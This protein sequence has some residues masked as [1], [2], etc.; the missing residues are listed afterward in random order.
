MSIALTEDHRALAETATAFLARRDARGSARSLL[1]APDEGLPPWWAELADLGWLGLHVPEELGGSG[2]TLEETAV[3]IEQLGRAVAPGPFVPTVIASA[4]LATC[5]GAPAKDHVPGLTDGTTLGAV[6]L[7]SATTVVVK[8][9]KASGPAGNVLGGGLAHVIL[10][11][12][13]DDVAVIDVAEAGT[14]VTVDV[15][16]NMDPTRR[17]ARVTLD[18]APVTV[19]PGARQVLVDLA[20]VVLSAEAVGLAREC[21]EMAAAY[22]KERLQFGRPIAMFQAV[23]HHCA[24]MAVATELATSA[25]WDAAKASST[26]GDQLSYAAAVAATLAAPLP[27]LCANLNTQVHGGIAIT[28][29]HD[30]HLFMRR[31]TVLLG[32]LDPEA[33]AIDVTDLVRRGVTRAKTVELPPEAE[34]IRQEVR[35]FAE[36][37]KGM[38]DERAARCTH[39]VRVRDAAL[40]PALWARG[41]RGRAARRRAGVRGGGHHPPRLR[42]HRLGHPHPD[43]VRHR[44]SGRTVGATCAQPRRRSGASCSPSPTPGRTP[45]ASR[46]RPPA[47]RVAGS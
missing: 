24:N 12:T 17:T 21:T 35:A 5:G 32:Y 20:R 9:G 38:P 45:L 1:E 42:H 18:N 3:V 41:G 27:N 25:V 36:S 22:S 44:R 40:A 14:T 10:V 34:T 47:S 37:I 43:P 15:P 33:A 39:Q 4:V 29:E 2:Y 11:A 26:G 46:P 7:G 28:W 6:A 8:D 31:A 13:G 19:L 30:A 16:R 23:K